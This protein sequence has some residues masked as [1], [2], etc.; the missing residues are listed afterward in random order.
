[1]MQIKAFNNVNLDP[2]FSLSTAKEYE[3]KTRSYRLRYG[4]MH[5][6]DIQSAKSMW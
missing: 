4:H 3:T 5:W 6:P 1:M 2:S